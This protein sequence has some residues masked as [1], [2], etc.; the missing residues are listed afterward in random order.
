MWNG[1][2]SMNSARSMVPAP[3]SATATPSSRS[4]SVSTA[5]PDA[6]DEA[7][8][9]VDAD[10]GALDALGQ[11][12]HRRGAGVDDVRLHLEPDRAH[13]QRVLDALL[14][15]DHEAA[16]QYVQHLAVGRD[17]DRAGDLGGSLDVLARDLAPRAADGHRAAR[18]L[19]LDVVAAHGHDGRLDPVAGKTARPP[20]A[21]R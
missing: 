13:A 11:V 10:V 2:P 7:D 5:S 21:R 19:A 16:R 12:L 20:R 8:Q 18:V 6:S 1:E 3:K 9:L 14:A 17:G 4:V 15:V